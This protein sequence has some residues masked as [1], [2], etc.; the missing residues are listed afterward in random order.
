MEIYIWC[1]TGDYPLYPDVSSWIIGHALVSDRRITGQ[2]WGRHVA[3]CRGTNSTVRSG[4]LPRAV[5]NKRDLSGMILEGAGD[6]TCG[7]NIY[8]LCIYIYIYKFFFF[9]LFCLIIYY[10]LF[11]RNILIFFICYFYLFLIIYY[12]LLLFI[13]LLLLLFIYLYLLLF[14]III[15]VLFCGFRTSLNDNI[16]LFFF[17]SIYIYIFKKQ[18]GVGDVNLEDY[19]SDRNWFIV[20]LITTGI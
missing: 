13:Y 6:G 4:Q 15:D 2:P 17:W 19:P 20:Q 8:I 3:S 9:F 7:N 14:I 5:R 16:R 1:I 12:F 18:N 10:Y 11:L